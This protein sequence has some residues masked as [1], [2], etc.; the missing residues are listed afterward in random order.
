M[1][2]YFLPFLF[3]FSNN[4]LQAQDSFTLDIHLDKIPD[5]TM[6]YLVQ[7]STKDTINKSLSFN[8]RVRLKGRVSNGTDYY[9][10]K[11]DS[12]IGVR[13][14][15][16]LLVNQ[17]MVINAKL[18]NWPHVNLTGSIPYIEYKN[19]LDIWNENSR[20]LDSLESI[21]RHLLG[22]LSESENNLDS[23]R[24]KS[25]SKKS[26]IIESQRSAL[27]TQRNL[28]ITKYIKD[29]RNSLYISDLILKLQR[30]LPLADRLSLYNRLTLRAKQSYFG[31]QLKVHLRQA[32]N[33]K[34]ITQ[35]SQ[36]PELKIKLPSGKSE[37]VLDYIKSNRLTLID[38]WAS[39][40]GPCRSEVANLKEVYSIFKEK[41]FSIIGIAINDKEKDW[42]KAI[43]QDST[44]WLQG[45]D[46]AN[47]AN[48]IFDIPAIPA[49]ILLDSEG[50]LI[51]L[52]CPGSSTASFGPPLKGKD[53]LS[54]I[55]KTFSTQPNP[56]KL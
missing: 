15:L 3:F 47:L 33:R 53:L 1:K 55:K 46:V 28:K 8:N 5:G 26:E 19:S 34:S 30:I 31:Q 27:I 40:C 42:K 4:L 6:F 24:I 36:F 45:M 43:A 49:Y 44:T 11:V 52:S 35:G 16:L 21:Q 50:K 12:C 25:L 23:N 38:F 2:L 32:T 18:E 9:L 39:W 22:L 54:T 48:E 41:G 29:H 37:S 20:A 13:P 51:S 56:I 7:T 14:A 17:P 10:V